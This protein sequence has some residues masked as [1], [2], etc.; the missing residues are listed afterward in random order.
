MWIKRGQIDQSLLE[1]RQ[2]KRKNRGNLKRAAR[3]QQIRKPFS[4]SNDEIYARL[5]VCETKNEYYKVSGDRCRHKHLL[6]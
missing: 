3:R 1:Y 4:L 5:K 6:N 2:G